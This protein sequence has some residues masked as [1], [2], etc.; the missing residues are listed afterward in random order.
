M[1]GEI[2]H[3]HYAPPLG[4]EYLLHAQVGRV[5]I[6]RDVAVVVL[7][8]EQ[9]QQVAPCGHHCVCLLVG[10]GGEDADDGLVRGGRVGVLAQ[11][12]QHVA[13]GGRQRGHGALQQSGLQQPHLPHRVLVAARF[14]IGLG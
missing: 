2:P 12:I 7:G 14:A 11:Q 8:D 4:I 9:R 5:Q 6:L 1:R 13:L 10:E 3:V